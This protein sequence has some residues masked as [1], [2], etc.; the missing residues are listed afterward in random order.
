MCVF[1]LSPFI[2]KVFLWL[3]N[4]KIPERFSGK[5]S[6][7]QIFHGAPGAYGYSVYE[8]FNAFFLNNIAQ[9][10]PLAELSQ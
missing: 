4:L 7:F 5:I 2:S 9:V 8:A 1:F 10:A 6:N 3:R